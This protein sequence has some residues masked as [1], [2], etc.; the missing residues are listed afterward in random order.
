MND[1]SNKRTILIIASAIDAILG[2]IV[3]LI[4]FGFLPVD[5]SSWG[6]SRGV[7]GIVGGLWFAAAL[8]VL[9]YQLMKTE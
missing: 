6:I 1:N 2:G 9:L 8:A 5:L 7:I 4:Y 3:L